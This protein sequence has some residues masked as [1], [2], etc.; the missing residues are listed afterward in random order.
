MQKPC[1]YCGMGYTPTRT[2][3]VYCSGRCGKNARNKKYRDAK[4]M[5][6]YIRGYRYGFV[7][8]EF[9]RRIVE[10]AGLCLACGRPFG[11]ETPCIDHDHA[12][13]DRVAPT[14]GKCTRGLLHQA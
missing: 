12:C 1:R 4:D 13:C 2:Q 5:R 10:Q 3:R 9:E 8:G 6:A 7:P 14:C 11:E